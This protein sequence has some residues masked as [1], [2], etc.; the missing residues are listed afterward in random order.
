MGEPVFTGG[1]K[2]LE[3]S[4]LLQKQGLTRQNEGVEWR[5]SDKRT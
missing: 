4:T 1:R 5:A 3:I 2:E